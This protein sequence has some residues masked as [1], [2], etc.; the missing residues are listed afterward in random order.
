MPNWRQY[1]TIGIFLYNG[2]EDLHFGQKERGF[3]I[4]LLLGNLYIITLKKLPI[5]NPN[6]KKNKLIINS[7]IVLP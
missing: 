2:I 3:T 1:V 7:I 4:D 6:N 5:I